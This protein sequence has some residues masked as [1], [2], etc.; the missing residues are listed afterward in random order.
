MGDGNYGRTFAMGDGNAWAAMF[1]MGDGNAW[2]AAFALRT[3]RPCISKAL[4]SSGWLASSGFLKCTKE[5]N[6]MGVQRVASSK[7]H[8]LILMLTRDKTV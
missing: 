1:A 6:A 8:E 7:L 3:A 4:G 2:A 5:R